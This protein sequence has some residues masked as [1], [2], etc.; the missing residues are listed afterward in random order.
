M[1]AAERRA[2]GDSAAFSDT[3]ILEPTADLVERDICALSGM[4]AGDGCPVRVR[5][6]VPAG[7]PDIPCSWHHVGDEGLLTVWPVEYRQWARAHGLD[8]AAPPR[9][10]A[11]VHAHT[12]VAAPAAH[13]V[14]LAIVSPPD[15]ATYLIDPTLRRE[16]QAVPLRVAAESRGPIEWSVAGHVVGTADA[17]AALDWPLA[18]GR[19]Q[20]VAR[21]G[22]G[23]T[24]EATITVR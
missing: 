19:H 9:I 7:S 17:S 20:I 6:W 15:D 23:R 3:P 10:A 16:F 14:A 8:D 22:R 11:V 12:T 5:E 13:Q 24:A 21:D 4:P 1:L 18:P 2:A